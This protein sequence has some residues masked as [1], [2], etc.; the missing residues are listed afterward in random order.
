MVMVMVMQTEEG[1]QLLSGRV[2]TITA[3]LTVGLVVDSLYTVHYIK[4]DQ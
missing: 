3:H 4:L 2:T 1:L